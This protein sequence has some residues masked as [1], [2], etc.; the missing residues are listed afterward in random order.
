MRPRES[1]A[2]GILLPAGSRRLIVKATQNHGHN[3]FRDENSSTKRWGDSSQRWSLLILQSGPAK[4]GA[5][6][7][8]YEV[9]L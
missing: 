4:P 3:C 9:L 8:R 7:Q 2:R 5:H 6:S 1:P